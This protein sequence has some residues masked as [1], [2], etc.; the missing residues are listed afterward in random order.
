MKPVVPV[1][2]QTRLNTSD[3]ETQQMVEGA[4]PCRIRES[5]LGRRR[6][7]LYVAPAERIEIRR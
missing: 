1:K 2:G 5:L 3:R 4:H 7:D 6:G